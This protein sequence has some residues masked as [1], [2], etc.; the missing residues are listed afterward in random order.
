[1]CLERCGVG[2]YDA[3][4]FG[5][6]VQKNML[7]SKDK[8]RQNWEVSGVNEN[9]AIILRRIPAALQSQRVM[10]KLGQHSER[11][12]EHDPTFSNADAR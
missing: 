8:A 1:M 4:V 6:L 2:G 7:R 3:A 11:R 12:S 9:R 5:M 10:L